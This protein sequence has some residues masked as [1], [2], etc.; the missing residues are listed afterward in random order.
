MSAIIFLTV[1]K[2]IVDIRD[3]NGKIA[4][5]LTILNYPCG[6]WISCR[7]IFN[8]IS[9]GLQVALSKN[10]GLNIGTIFQKYKANIGKMVK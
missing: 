2:H 4:S 3:G 8:S 9:E 6:F 1:Q 5:R 7:A 10:I